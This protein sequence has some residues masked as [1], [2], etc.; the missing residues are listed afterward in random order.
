MTIVFYWLLLRS[1]IDLF[2]IKFW[3]MLWMFFLM[4]TIVIGIFLPPIRFIL[5]FWIGIFIVWFFLS[6]KFLLSFMWISMP[7]STIGRAWTWGWVTRWWWRWWRRGPISMSMAMMMRFE[8]SFIFGFCIFMIFEGKIG[9]MLM[10]IRFSVPTPTFT[11]LL[12]STTFFSF[13]K[14]HVLNL[15]HQL[16]K[17]LYLWIIQ[18]H[19]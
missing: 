5:I 19:N 6:L 9:R 8:I 11:P 4:W 1:F 13:F 10:M 14:W 17:H 7:M 12:A 18:F 2:F 15:L 3:K 16:L